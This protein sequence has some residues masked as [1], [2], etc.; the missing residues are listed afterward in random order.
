MTKALPKKSFDIDEFQQLIGVFKRSMSDWYR[1]ETASLHCPHSHLEIMQFIR[2]RKNPTMKEIAGFLRITPPSVTTIIDVMEQNKL[3]KR[4]TLANDRRSVRI[5][6]TP[7]AQ[8]L[9]LSLQKKKAKLL[10][11]MLKKLSAEQKQHLSDII[12]TLAK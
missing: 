6:L 4:V 3:V 1:K 9:A 2:E 5:A 7:K 10:A 8:K 11:I 12:S